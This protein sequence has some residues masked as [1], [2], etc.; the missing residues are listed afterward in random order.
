MN[1][2]YSFSNMTVVKLPLVANTVTVAAS[3]SVQAHVL[4]FRSAVLVH[5]GGNTAIYFGDSDVD[6][7]KGI[8][9]A[10][11]MQMIFPTIKETAVYLYSVDVNDGVV[12]A[13]FFD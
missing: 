2:P 6:S 3:D 7:D 13:E 11:G 4:T 10:V 9:I 12:I 5:N 1:I 8:P